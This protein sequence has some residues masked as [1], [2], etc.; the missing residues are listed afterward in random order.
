MAAAMP[1]GLKALGYT[2]ATLLV[3]LSAM[4]LLYRWVTGG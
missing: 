2:L 1:S 4:I 3:A